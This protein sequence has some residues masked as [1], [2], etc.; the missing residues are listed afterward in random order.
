VTIELKMA[1]WSLILAL[2]QIL[3][4]DV[5]RTAQYGTRWNTGPRDETMPPLNPVVGR[6][7]RAQDNLFETLPL[8]VGAVLL[9]HV[10]GRESSVTAIGT[11]I[12][13]WGR[14]VYI[15]L[16]VLGVRH[17]RSLIWLISTGG[18]VAIFYA[19]VAAQ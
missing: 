15:P 8:F 17:V 2:V 7:K 4:F 14:V 1:S 12:Y 3:L 9:A 16:Y 5:A 19:I 10:T 13:F 6:L 18:L 11:Q